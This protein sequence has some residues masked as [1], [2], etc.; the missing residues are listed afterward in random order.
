VLPRLRRST[1]PVPAPLVRLRLLHL[2]LFRLV[3]G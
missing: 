1:E 2:V 3:V